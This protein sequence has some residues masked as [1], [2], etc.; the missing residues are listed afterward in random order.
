MTTTTLNQAISEAESVDLLL[1]ARAA[2]IAWDYKFYLR[3]PDRM[4]DE[5]RKKLR[6]DLNVSHNID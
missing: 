4:T 2:G 5:Q 6:E 3:H 1:K